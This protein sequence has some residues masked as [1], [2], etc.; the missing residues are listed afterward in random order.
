MAT[1]PLALPLWTLLALV[2]RRGA[3]PHPVFAATVSWCSEEALRQLDVEADE[4]LRRLG[5]SDGRVPHRRLES[6]L[7]ALDRPLR[8]YYGWID[9]TVDGSPRSYSVLAARC[10]E[11]AVVA[12]NDPDSAVVVLAAVRGEALGDEF[13]AQ[14]PPYRTTRSA[15]INAPYQELLR[16]SA[17]SRDAGAR[18][19]KAL[20]AAPRTGAGNLYS[21]VRTPGGRKRIEH[22]VNY[23]DTDEGRWLTLLGGSSGDGDGSGNGSGRWATA[24]PATPELIT[25]R[26]A[27][28]ADALTAGGA[29]GFFV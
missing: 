27:E 18:A 4:V 20:F 2:R 13:A 12:V 1:D 6:A 28:A 3:E 19:M 9:T 23:I 11:D 7:R 26:L 10:G 16:P 14:L 29:P 21:A 8:E 25:R 5:L 17:R 15:S 24:T 22:P